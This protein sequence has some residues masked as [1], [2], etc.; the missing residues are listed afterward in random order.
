MELNAPGLKR[1]PNKD[2]TVRHYWVASAVSKNA[3]DYPQKT[4]PVFGSDE[5]IAH[6]CR[7]LSSELKLWLSNRGLGAKPLYDGSLKSLIK[8]YRETEESPYHS[9]KHNTREM[10]DESLDLLVETVGTRQLSRLSGLDFQRWYN[11]LKEPAAH[12]EKEIA[13]AKKAGTKLE[14]KP[15]RVRRAYKAMQMLRI[16]VKFGIVANVTECARLAVV[17]EQMRFHVPP[18]RTERITFQQVEAICAKAIE[19]GRLSIALAQAL[20][21]ELTLR[22]VDVIGLWEPLQDRDEGQ[23]IVSGRRRWTGGLAWSH[24]DANGILSKVTTKTGQVAEH[25]TTAY[26]FLRSILDHIPQEKRIGPMI[27]DESTGLPYRDRQ[28]FARVWRAIA[29]EC[30]VPRDV[31]NRDSR[32]GGV[33][34]G[35]DA[36]ANIEHLRHHANHANIAT[37]AR[38]NRNTIEKTR[39]VA[40]LRVAHRT[41]KNV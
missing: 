15:E 31:W 24:I 13:L 34:E 27:V 19:Q 2:G 18:A 35:S 28:R 12:T 40:E 30:G 14:P 33:T 41:P 8:V 16:V 9:I 4:V 22:Q 37:T 32:A 20:Q 39:T 26:P 17:L 25:D 21:F 23:G 5:E 36:G 10:Y 29:N 7:V 38:Y 1:R 6:R 3:K 11:K